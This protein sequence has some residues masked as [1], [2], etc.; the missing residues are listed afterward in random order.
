MDQ[1]QNFKFVAEQFADIRILRYLVPGFDK[2]TLQQ[3]K[4][5]YYLYEAALSGRDMIYDQNYKYNLLI[6]RTLEHIVKNYSGERNSTEWESFLV[7]VKRVWFSNGIHHHNSMDKFVPDISP[8]YFSQLLHDAGF[9]KFMEC[10][11]N[12]EH[13]IQQII[14]LIFDK[15]LDNKR[16]VLDEGVDMIV[17]SS[18][19]FYEGVT[20][21]EVEDFYRKKTNANVKRPVSHGLNSKVIKRNGNIVEEVWKMDGIYDAAIRQI[22]FWL[23]K[24]ASVSESEHQQAALKELIAFYQ[25]GDL[26]RFDTY[27]I[28]W[29][30]DTEPEVDVIN[31]F[32]E[33]YGDPL[34]RKAT[35]ESV[36]SIED[37]EATRRAKT[38]SDNAQWFEEH[39][40]IPA[41][42]KKQ[43]FTGVSAKGINVVVESGDCA[44]T[45]PVG[46]NLPNAEWI[47]E[48]FGS[49][50]VTINNIMTAYD[51]ASKE[52][53]V[54]EEFAWSPEEVELSKK[55]GNLAALLHVDLHEIVGHGSGKLK[56]GIANTSDTLKNYASTIEETRADLFALYFAID[57]QLIELGL[58]PEKAIGVAEYNSYIRGGLM[59]QLVRVELGKNIEESHMRNRQL[60]A[61]WAYE[62]GL[63][64]NVIEKKTRNGK[65]FFVVNDHA[66]LRELFG[67]LLHEVQR[68]K[69]EG[70]FESAKYLVENYG[71]KVNQEIHKE[72][73]ERWEKLK[74]APFA[75]FINP[76]LIPVIENDEILDII[77][78]YPENFACQMLDY[79]ENYSFLPVIT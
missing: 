73:L 60:I 22:I 45:S 35:F 28:Q 31:G 20:Q 69:S 6:R 1:K 68:I 77:I 41:Q 5:I 25:T 48:E 15:D 43:Q 8:D 49:K 40:P 9:V 13:F 10:F 64:E 11:G 55:W 58:M 4:L 59:T 7:Y 75:G 50:S 63:P 33:V 27:N 21:D 18:N 71:V 34:G 52:S 38:I 19:N 67:E 12:M 16:V 44:P 61:A 26:K 17:A 54:I 23:E 29:L 14:P 30:R 24:A 79:A 57:D 47:R 53:G 56:A 2:L 36:V 72:V 65:T 74:I 66:R 37:R 46:I 42:Y 62:K 39:A 51:E 3:K 32:I 76:K 78:G 70:D